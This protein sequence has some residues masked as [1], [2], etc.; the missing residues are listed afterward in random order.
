MWDEDGVEGVRVGAAAG[1]G[2]VSC[3]GIVPEPRGNQ[4]GCF[5]VEQH[6]RFLHS[7]SAVQKRRQQKTQPTHGVLLHE[8]GK[9]RSQEGIFGKLQDLGERTH[10]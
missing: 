9:A 8:S 2:R 10:A 6:V 5:V 4:N 1:C 3:P 7:S